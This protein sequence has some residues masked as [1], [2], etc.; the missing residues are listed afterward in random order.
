MKKVDEIA[1]WKSKSVRLWSFKLADLL[2]VEPKLAPGSARQLNEFLGHGCFIINCS[3]WTVKNYLCF[4]SLLWC[5]HK[6]GRWSWRFIFHWAIFIWFDKKL[7]IYC[8]IASTLITSFRIIAFL[9]QVL[10]FIMNI[11]F[12]HTKALNILQETIVLKPKLST[13]VH[14]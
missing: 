11:C 9:L 3:F 13:G 7:P 1:Y 14:F 6:F 5:Q 10:E 4:T 12:S 8:I 2:T